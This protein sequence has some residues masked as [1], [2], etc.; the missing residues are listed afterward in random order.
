[1]VQA[2]IML[3]TGLLW[4][5]QGYFLGYQLPFVVGKPVLI[6][7]GQVTQGLATLGGIV[8]LLLGLFLLYERKKGGNNFEVGLYYN[9]MMVLGIVLLICTIL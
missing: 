1:M 9:T 3:V 6:V 2:I 4:L 7:L 8:Y 5:I